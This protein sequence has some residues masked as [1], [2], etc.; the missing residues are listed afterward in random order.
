MNKIN[1]EN[2]KCL[3]KPHKKST[4]CLKELK[5]Y[6]PRTTDRNIKIKKAIENIT[7]EKKSGINFFEYKPM[8]INANLIMKSDD[9]GELYLGSNQYKYSV[10]NLNCFDVVVNV[11]GEFPE[12]TFPTL[13]V[14]ID[15]GNT[16]I[17]HRTVS[18][19]T[20]H[21]VEFYVLERESYLDY[22]KLCEIIHNNFLEGK[23]VLIHCQQGLIRS[24][25]LLVFYLRKYFFDDIHSAN[26]FIGLKRESAC[27]SSIVFSSIEKILSK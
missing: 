9:G 3:L 21:K 2:N 10:T 26:D 20:E 17:K 16:N 8:L 19:D 24:A 12:V 14:E 15:E 23:R 27:A 6:T 1:E 25:T 22:P 18:V 4:S 13:K 7:E 5:E 11:I